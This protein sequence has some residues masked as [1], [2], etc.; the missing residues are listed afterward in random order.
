MVPLK[1]EA[2]KGNG[3]RFL[4]QNANLQLNEHQFAPY[5]QITREAY[6][7]YRGRLENKNMRFSI[8]LNKLI[9]W[10]AE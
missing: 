5:L 7:N 8:G 6:F 9:N 1:K 10:R 4:S 3:F 2:F